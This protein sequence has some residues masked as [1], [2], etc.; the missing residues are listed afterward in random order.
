MSAGAF[1]LSVISGLWSYDGWN[2]LNYITAEMKNPTRDLPRSLFLGMGL[3]IAIYIFVNIAYFAVLPVSSIVDFEDGVPNESFAADFAQATLGKA[4]LVIIPLCISLSAFGAANGTATLFSA[5]VCFG[6][7]VCECFGVC[8]CVCVCVCVFQ[9]VFCAC[10][11]LCGCLA[12]P[13]M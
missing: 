9:C 8:V 3:V 5:S 12:S 6:V 11:C 1:G 10:L 7:C 2:N 4:G 13:P